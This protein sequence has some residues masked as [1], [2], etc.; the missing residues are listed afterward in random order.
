MASTPAN[1][2]ASNKPAQPAL[3]GQ[4]DAFLD[5]LTAERGASENTKAAYRRDLQDLVLYLTPRK[6]RISDASSDDLHGYFSDLAGRQGQQNPRTAARR[7]SAFRQFYKFLVS[8]KL[9]VDD[10]SRH[11]SPPK[12]GRPLPKTL[13]E[14]EVTALIDATGKWSDED[15]MR[16]ICLLELLYATGLRVSELVGMKLTSFD[17]E[18]QMVTVR[19]KGGRERIVPLGD[20]ARSALA[21]YLPV[22][23]AYLP[24]GQK[25]EDNPWLFPSTRASAGHLTRQRFGQLVK[26]LALEAGINPGKISPHVLRH[27]F[28]THL[29][30]HG[31]DLRVVQQ[32]LGHA[33]IATTQIYTH[34]SGDRLRKAVVENHPLAQTGDKT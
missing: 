4:V 33:D 8:E 11:I 15:Q 30:D 19:G 22:R 32:L 16:L 1:K 21:R 31:A 17:R 2:P 23:G 14:E 7:L 34:V 26:E 24:A 18:L 27:A 29:L 9:R 25:P 3:P 10:P 6:I 12:P 5:M 20:G 13:S 28:A